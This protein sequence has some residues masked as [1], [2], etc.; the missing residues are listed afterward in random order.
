MRRAAVH[1]IHLDTHAAAAATYFLVC[2][3]DV[4]PGAQWRHRCAVAREERRDVTSGVW[5]HRRDVTPG[6]QWR[7]R[8]A[9]AREERA[10][11]GDVLDGTRWRDLVWRWT[12]GN[13]DEN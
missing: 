8:C 12:G 6:A 5:R 9:V 11:Y 1:R 10:L 7:H 2:G 13:R 4:T 3:R